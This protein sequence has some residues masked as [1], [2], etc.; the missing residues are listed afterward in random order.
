MSGILD[1]VAIVVGLI[2]DAL[3]VLFFVVAWFAWKDEKND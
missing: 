1:I 3:I 2:T